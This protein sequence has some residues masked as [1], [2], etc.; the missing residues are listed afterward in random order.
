M[1]SVWAR[2]LSG[3]GRVSVAHFCSDF[4]SE[5]FIVKYSLLS[6]LLQESGS[7]QNL[8][9]QATVVGFCRSS[10]AQAATAALNLEVFV[11]PRG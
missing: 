11:N 4:A 3:G 7:S 1:R 6:S 8:T 2:L 9:S 5:A 10:V